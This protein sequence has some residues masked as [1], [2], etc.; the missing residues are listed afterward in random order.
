MSYCSSLKENTIKKKYR[1]LEARVS[2]H[3]HF[4]YENFSFNMRLKENIVDFFKKYEALSQD[5]LLV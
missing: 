4:H 5:E 1:I 2:Q 3:T